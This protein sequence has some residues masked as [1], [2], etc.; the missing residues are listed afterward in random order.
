[1]LLA[2]ETE[3][4]VEAA[5][6]FMENAWLIPL[7]PGL[8]FFAILLFGKRMPR[9]GSEFGIASMLAAFVIASGITSS[10]LATRVT[11]ALVSGARTPRQL[12]HLLTGALV[13]TTFAVPST[14]GRAALALPVFVCLA[15]VFTDRPQLVRALAL[16][17]PTVILLSAVGSLLG[18]GAPVALTPWGLFRRLEKIFHKKENYLDARRTRL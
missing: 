1:M 8:A 7:I 4:A 11:A 18:A 13:I 16:L 12:T 9:G 14:S 17:F 5:G 10:G 6:W 15:R 3:H 2:Q